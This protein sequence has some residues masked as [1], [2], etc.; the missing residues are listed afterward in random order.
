M[1]RCHDIFMSKVIIRLIEEYEYYNW[2]QSDNLSVLGLK[3]SYIL[4]S[5][6]RK[7]CYEKNRKNGKFKRMQCVLYFELTCRWTHVTRTSHLVVDRWLKTQSNKKVGSQHKGMVERH[8]MCH[9]KNKYGRFWGGTWLVTLSN[10]WCSV[11]LV[12]YICI[13]YMIWELFARK[14]KKTLL[15]VTPMWLLNM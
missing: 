14:G 3:F 11:S 9:H 6:I 15:Y 12:A 5:E 2:Y 10:V 7:K 1:T 4:Y 8:D 13:A